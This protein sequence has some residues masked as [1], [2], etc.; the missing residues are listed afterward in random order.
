[1]EKLL[2]LQAGRTEAEEKYTDSTRALS[3]AEQRFRELA[4]ATSEGLC[5]VQDAVVRLANPKFLALSE[6]T[7]SDLHELPFVELVHAEDRPALV[8]Q[9]RKRQEGGFQGFK[10]VF[11]LSTKQGGA[12]WVECRVTKFDWAGR[13]ALLYFFNEAPDAIKAG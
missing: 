1:M 2:D 9:Y 10:S 8:E 4:E 12:R 13:P 11:R 3:E 6:Y 7:E 5:V